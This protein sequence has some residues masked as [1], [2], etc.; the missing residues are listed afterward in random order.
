MKLRMITGTLILLLFAGSLLGSGDPAAEFER[1]IAELLQKRQEVDAQEFLQVTERRMTDFLEKYPD[2]PEAVEV[3]L[4]L[5]QLF[6]QAGF[7]DKAVYHLE[8]YLARSGG[9][10]TEEVA[11]A[12][13]F[14][15]QG[16]IAQDEF[17]KAER[18]LQEV[19]AVGDLTS[20]QLK[21]MTEMSLQRIPILKKLKIG[22]PALPID[23][24]TTV[25]DRITLESF[26]GRVLLVDFWASWCKPC[27]QEMP[28]V[29]SVYKEFHDKGFE[30]L[31]VSLDQSESS[32]RGYIEEQGITWPQ[33][34]DGGGW[35]SSVGKLYG[36][37][38]I[39]ATFLIDRNGTIR[40]R[41]LRGDKLREA[42]RELVEAE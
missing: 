23:A 1:M 3:H 33:I 26:K 42:V 36:V 28:T 20:S 6:A 19:R 30:I 2:S 41:D 27:R 22:N 13:F 34:F 31:G 10:K 15:A 9:R 24:A 16:Y 12:K 37:Y 17:D 25:G 4:N 21:Q 14:L 11:V 8:I 18:Y 35:K 7:P 40:Y 38:S 29:K 5:G 39:P 32:F